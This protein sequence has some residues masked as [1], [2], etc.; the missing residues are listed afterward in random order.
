MNARQ[1]S[2]ADAAGVFQIGS[3]MTACIHERDLMA[4]EKTKE[5][6]DK[7]KPL[8]TQGKRKLYTL[9]DKFVA[10]E[11]VA[12]FDSFRTSEAVTAELNCTPTPSQLNAALNACDMDKKIIFV[13]RDAMISHLEQQLADLKEEMAAYLGLQETPVERVPNCAAGED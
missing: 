12:T 10:G 8:S 2:V 4:D 6:A 3:D 7:T 13:T 5:D 1:Y 9:L 11:E